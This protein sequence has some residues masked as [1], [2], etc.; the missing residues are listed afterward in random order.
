LIILIKISNPNKND[1]QAIFRLSTENCPLKVGGMTIIC[2]YSKQHSWQ[3]CE[4]KWW[5]EI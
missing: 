3:Q 5:H 2:R 4:L 1:T